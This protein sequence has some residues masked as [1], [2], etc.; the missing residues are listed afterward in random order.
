MLDKVKEEILRMERLWVIQKVDQPSEWCHPIVIVGKPNNKIRLCID[1]T[2]LNLGVKREFYQLES[3]EESISKLGTNCKVM[4]KLDANSGY[5][6][7]PL[8]EQSQLLTT[9]ITPIGRYCCTRGPFGLSSMQEIF[10]K[11]IDYII[12]G[13]EGVV[14]STDDFL[15]F[16]K[17]KTEHDKRLRTLLERLKANHVTLN[18]DKC[19][20]NKSE[21]E[22]IGHKVNGNGVKPLS[23]RIQAISEYKV[24]VNIT[25]L[26]RFL[27]MANQ[28]SKY[29]TK[30]ADAASP[31]RDL[32]S[33]KNDWVWDTAHTKAFEKVKQVLA[34]PPVL[35][36]FSPEKPTK[37]RTD[38]SKLNVI[39]VILSQQHEGVWKPV[40][41]ASR[42]YRL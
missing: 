30:L 3:V 26:R 42:F 28:L 19:E 34:Q 36:H 6:Q 11:K 7:V 32:L 22:F 25:E 38:G 8:N 35:V 37:I 20:F 2:K 18:K 13:L 14:K 1:L 9:F 23:S 39:A 41:C 5:W 33:T 10:N 29:S 27:G 12:D 40:A 24:P 31:L 16:G 21:V 4:S 17:D 15:V